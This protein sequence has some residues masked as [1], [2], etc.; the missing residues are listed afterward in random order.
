MKTNG[1]LR[2][3]SLS[4]AQAE[5][6]F[7]K[8]CGSTRWASR[9]VEERPFENPAKLNETAERI[10]WSLDPQDWLEAFHSHPK[11]GEKKAVAV[12]SDEAKRWS[13]AEQAAV[14]DA[15]GETLQQLAELNQQ[16]E[17]KFGYIFIVCATGKTSEEMLAI[18]RER[19]NNDPTEELRNAA[20]EQAKIMQ[21]R[22]NKLIDSLPA[23]GFK[24][25][26]A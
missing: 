20:A 7:L 9:M 25:S 8:C 14:N 19:L 22:L 12:T 24:P 2:L 10:W 18:L 13:E 6:E 15:A 16:Y 5:N 26:Q 21:L 17:Q 11:I 4:A 1:A 23:S 3:N